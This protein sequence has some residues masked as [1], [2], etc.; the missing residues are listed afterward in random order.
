[1]RADLNDYS[2][3]LR[4]FLFGGEKVVSNRAKKT[5][6]K[7]DDNRKAAP[8]EQNKQDDGLVR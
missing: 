6:I 5:D 8:A 4:L 2:V 7:N 3:C 1:M